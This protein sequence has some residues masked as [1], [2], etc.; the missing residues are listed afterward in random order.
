MMLLRLVSHP[1]N[2]KLHIDKFIALDNAPENLFF[3]VKNGKRFLKEFVDVDV[4]ENIPKAIR[5]EFCLGD[6]VYRFIPPAEK[7]MSGFDQELELTAIVLDFQNRN[8]AETWLTLERMIEAMTPRDKKTPEPVVVAKD[9][10]SGF[11]IGSEDIP[12]V[13][14]APSPAIQE[15]APVRKKAG[16]PRKMVEAA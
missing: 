3:N 9:H 1:K 11:T 13:D 15:V 8:G 10:H 2:N 5:E 4:P 16:R 6:K 12:I 7:G 14:L